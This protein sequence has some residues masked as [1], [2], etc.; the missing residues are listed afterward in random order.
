MRGREGRGPSSGPAVP[1]TLTPGSETLLFAQRRTMGDPSPPVGRPAG[2]PAPYLR[3]NGWRSQPAFMTMQLKERRFFRQSAQRPLRGDRPLAPPGRDRL[4]VGVGIRMAC[5]NRFNRIRS[6]PVFG[7]LSIL[8]ITWLESCCS[9]TRWADSP[10]HG[11]PCRK[12]IGRPACFDDNC[13]LTCTAPD[14]STKPQGQGG[15]RRLLCLITVLADV[16]AKIRGSNVPHELA[17]LV[18]FLHTEVLSGVDE[19]SASFLAFNDKVQTHTSL[20][21]LP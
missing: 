12:Y 10:C 14:G 4:L 9:T 19:T 11:R 21:F 8:R 2:H 18:V 5:P 15:G 16:E 7:F 20:V 17:P 13:A 6:Q 3:C 1:A